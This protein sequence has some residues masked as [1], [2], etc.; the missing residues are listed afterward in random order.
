M[1]YI[2]G[3]NGFIGRNIY[4]YLKKYDI[5]STCMDHKDIELLRNVIKDYDIV[6]NCCGINRA[7]KYEDYVEG[8]I[9]FVQ[10]LL[11]ILEKKPFLI[12]LSSSMTNGFLNKTIS[13][14]QEYFIETKKQADKILIE[15]YPGDKL[16]IIKPSNIYGYDCKP[17]TNNILVTLVYE[18]IM[19]EYKTVNINKNCVRN[20]LSID[21]LCSEIFNIIIN[22][23]SGIFNIKSTNNIDLYSVLKHIHE[24]KVPKEINILDEEY[25]SFKDTNYNNIIIQEDI[26][27]KIKELESDIR[28]YINLEKLIYV[29]QMN[30]LVQER[31][32]MVEISDLNSNRL[33]MI[34][35]NYNCQRGNHYHLE[36]IEHFYTLRGRVIFLLSHKDFKN[37]ISFKI[38]DLNSLL[39]VRPL[40]IHTL[41]NDFLSNECEILVSSTQRY[42]K[43]QSPDT[44]YT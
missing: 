38:L 15:S 6:I 8:N 22:R 39:I 20:F 42:I 28:N 41:I 12:H 33:Y 9:S 30:K 7:N 5:T 13:K 10:K 19:N 27:K 11:S 36:Q 43:G 4:L 34:T 14:Y 23:T 26:S 2:I 44:I 18:K 24:G 37:V 35:I 17:Y 16:C 21:G 3:I 25:N 29:K 32:E 40:V 1:I 31:G